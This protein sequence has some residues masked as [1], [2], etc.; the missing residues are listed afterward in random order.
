MQ[1]ENPFMAEMRATAAHI[2]TRGKVTLVAASL[3]KCQNCLQTCRAQ[4]QLAKHVLDS[5]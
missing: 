2:A 5:W 4:M 1:A 3:L